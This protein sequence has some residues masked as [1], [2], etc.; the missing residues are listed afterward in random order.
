[1]IQNLIKKLKSSEWLKNIGILSSGT[2]IAQL[3]IIAATPILSRIYQPKD[4]ALLALL[5]SIYSICSNAITLKYETAIMLPKRKE[6]NEANSIFILTILSSIFFG[7]VLIFLYFLISENVT[8]YIDSSIPK[9]W[10]YIGI[11]TGILFSIQAT[12]IAWFNRNKDFNKIG[13]LPILQNTTIIFIAL[14]LGYYTI[15]SGLLLAQFLG[16]LSA[17]LFSLLLIKPLSFKFSIDGMR[18]VA[19]KYKNAPKYLLPTNLID[20]VTQQWPIIIIFSFYSAEIAGQFSMAWR[21]LVLPMAL[22][23]A[24]IAQ[25]FYQRYANI[26]PNHDLARSE[27]LRTWRFLVIIGILPTIV[28][29]FFG[30]D[31]FIYILGDAWGEAGKMASIMSIMTYLRLITAPTASAFNVMS[32]QRYSLYFGLVLFF[33]RPLSFFLGFMMGDIYTGIIFFSIFEIIQI[34]LYQSVLIKHISLYTSS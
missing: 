22:L 10:I 13:V 1:M 4:F 20:I 5:I 8:E 7:L 31:L 18:N 34:I 30:E 21:I 14:I 6:E 25:V 27:I 11:L 9:R 2:I 32:I 26:W 29:L 33:A 23:G 15:E 12:C 16:I 19:V 28:I 24:A 3:V 17:S